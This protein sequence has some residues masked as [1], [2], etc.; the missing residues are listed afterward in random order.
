MGNGIK[1][2]LDNYFYLHFW[3]LPPQAI[4][5]FVVAALPAAIAGSALAPVVS[6]QFGK[7]AAMIG[8]FAAT[9]VTGI[10]PMI[11][12]LSGVFPPNG[13][14]WV[15]IILAI[16]IF[17]SAIL[18]LMGLI[19]I[20]SMIADVAEDVAVQTGKRSEGLLF[21]IYGL[22]PK[23]S[24]AA[25]GFVGAML[26]AFVHFP[27]HAQQGTVDPAIMRHLALIYLPVTT[28]LSFSSIFVMI[29]YPID[30]ARHERNLA[31]LA[32]RGL[33][34]LPEALVEAEAVEGAAA[35]QIAAI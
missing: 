8:L 10:A 5:G 19:L 1:A 21:S 18:G 14:I 9:I 2:T 3:N 29:V 33:A 31:I 13:S 28:I 15:N 20:A 25:G 6:K 30:E 24:A 35:G 27:D 7:K 32:E 17:V 23:V 11:F 22:L 12:K 4:S 16:D 34:H 26:L